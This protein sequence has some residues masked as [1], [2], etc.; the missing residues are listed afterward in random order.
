[1]MIKYLKDNDVSDLISTM[2]KHISTVHFISG[3]GNCSLILP[4]VYILVLIP[5]E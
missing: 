2:I 3:I 4:T 5:S 1:M